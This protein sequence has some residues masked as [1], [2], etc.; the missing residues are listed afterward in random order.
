MTSL[1]E[2]LSA[3]GFLPDF[4]AGM[5]VNYEIGGI[6]LVMGLL[7]GLPLA[8]AS[9]AGGSAKLLSGSLVSLMRAAPTFVVMFVLMNAIPRHANLLGIPVAPSGF[10]AVA[11]SL[12]PYA[13]SYVFD[14]GVEALKHLR[15]GAPVSALLFL[16]NMMR[17][18]FVLVMSSS[19]GAAIGVTEGVAVILRQTQQLPALHDK[20]LLFGIGVVC[21]GVPLQAGF[22]LVRILHR[23]LGQIALR[24]QGGWAATAV[25]AAASG[26]ITSF[27]EP[28]WVHH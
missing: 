20:L 18:F 21:F 17:A 12:A 16:P 6:A 5:A 22:A 28:G 14:N 13:A 4:L 10:L 19:A 7:I 25:S 23:R 8:Q 2:R 26:S 27:K 9:L 24:H 11:I 3:S 15:R 1:F